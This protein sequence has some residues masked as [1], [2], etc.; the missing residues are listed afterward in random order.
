M[1][2]MKNVLLASAASFVAVAAAGAADLPMKAKPVEYVKIC[3]VYGAGF[4]YIPGTNTCLKLGGYL[5]AEADLN[6]GGTL[7]PGVGPVIAGNRDFVDNRESQTLVER[8]R[9]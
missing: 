7:T 4:Y 2:T 9:I 5:R 1:T 3:S 8:T 6:A